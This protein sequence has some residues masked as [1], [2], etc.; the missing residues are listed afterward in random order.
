MAYQQKEIKDK[1]IL[2]YLKLELSDKVHTKS[3]KA[4]IKRRFPVAEIISFTFLKAIIP[5]L[6]HI[7]ILCSANISKFRKPATDLA[8]THCKITPRCLCLKA[9]ME[10]FMKIF[11]KVMQTFV[12]KANHGNK[13]GMPGAIFAQPLCVH[14]VVTLHQIDEQYLCNYDYT[15]KNS[16]KVDAG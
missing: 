5:K 3:E 7:F 10:R 8:F 1:F 12:L 14:L 11:K 2:H 4:F 13:M 6:D 16:M 15:K 9:K